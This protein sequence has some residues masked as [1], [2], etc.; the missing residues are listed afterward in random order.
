[1]AAAVLWFVAMMSGGFDDLFDWHHPTRS[2]P[3]VVRARDAAVP[4]IAQS[5]DAVAGQLAR[6][7]GLQISTVTG[8]AE[9]CDEGQHN[10][11]IDNDYDLLCTA[12][13]AVLLTGPSDRARTQVD[14]LLTALAAAGYRPRYPN[15]ALNLV[16]LHDRSASDSDIGPGGRYA[17]GGSDLGIELVAFDSPSYR[18]DSTGG[19]LRLR[20]DGAPLPPGVVPAQLLPA[21]RYGVWLTVSET[22][23]RA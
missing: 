14:A 8:T 6:A 13:T 10:F 4:R 3:E 12:A 2:S 18:L 16:G 7:S 20:R 15:A 17:R 9:W 23:F 11:K 21:G 1:V 19:D 22:Y 5:A